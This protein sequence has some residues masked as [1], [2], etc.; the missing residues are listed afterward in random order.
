MG[1][2]YRWRRSA[3]LI[4]AGLLVMAS[5][6][7]VPGSASARGENCLGGIDHSLPLPSTVPAAQFVN[8]EKQ[9]LGFLQQGEYRR[10]GWCVD[11]GVRDTG[12][13]IQGVYYGTHPVVRIYYS[14]QI[15]QWL[16]GGRQGT[17]P[18]GAMIVKEQFFQV[19][20]ARY[21]GLTEAQVTA[22][23]TER[24]GTVGTDWSIMIKDAQGAKDGWF[25]GRVL[26][27]YVVRR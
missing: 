20:A 19:P 14:P 22:L 6:F 4:V 15:M 8:L 21:A 25:W 2:G 24:V 27:R 11:K 12:P 7:A 10:L 13:F 5:C 3:V 18:D 23:F 1:A 16:L 9:I 26:R 17:I